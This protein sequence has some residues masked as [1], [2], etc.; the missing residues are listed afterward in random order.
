MFN[1]RKLVLAHFWLAFIAFLIALI[2]GEWQ[3]YV[4][5]PLHPGLSNPELYYRSVT[6]HGSAMAYV[7]PTLVAMGFGYAIVE[8][9]LKRP[10]VGLRWAW[11]GYIL[12]VV[13]T[14]VAMVPVA[15]GLASVLYTFYPPMI[16]NA[17]FYIGVVLVV[18]GSWIW[19]A[20]MSINLR[21]WK[22]DNPG[23]PIPL[24]MFAN[25]AGAY[26][27]AWTSVGASLEILFQILPVA[28]GFRNT[29]DAGLAR[30]LFS[31]TLHA[32]VYFWLFPAYIAF[33]TLIPRAIGGRLYSDMMGRV[34]FVLFLVF[35]MPIG[36]HHVFQ[37][38]QVGEGFKLLHAIFTGMVSVPTLLTVFTIT[39]SVE[40]AGRLRGGKGLLGWVKALPWKNPMMLA[41]AFSFIM[42][43][44]GGAGGIINMSYKMDF[45]VHNTQWI[46]GHFHLIFGGAIVIMYFA[47]AYDLWPHLTGKALDSLR[48]MRMQLWLW[49]IGMIVVTFPWHYAGILSI[50]RRMAYFDYSDPAIS[51][52]A[53]S[54]LITFFGGLL[55]VASAVLFIIVL[56]RGHLGSQIKL[57][58]FRFS[59]PVHQPSRVPIAL[60]SFALWLALMIGL[61]LV[62]YGFPI[63]KLMAVEE[64]SV[65]A[66]PVG[67]KR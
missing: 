23:T 20:L 56:A 15:M 59:I 24:P 39:A 3:M 7:F 42:L 47:I 50:P 51:P 33:Y 16:G 6:A 34:A 55:L 46:T 41:I 54:V 67:V 8:L 2:L 18:V 45:T 17:F 4:R 49:F 5:S 25:V 13:G 35:S 14:I 57:P 64:T 19:V 44:F 27:W 11:A 43:G 66:I 32:I 21:L 30:I 1:S 31:W 12:I 40:I 28:L 62:N 63:A 61:T 60:N 58:E 29:I 10:L 53:L 38:P 52:Q 65:P 22:K 9:A 26:L 36:I 48:L 37:D